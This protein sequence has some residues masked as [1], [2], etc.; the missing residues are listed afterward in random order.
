MRQAV[1]AV[2]LEKKQAQ[3]APE[4]YVSVLRVCL[5]RFHGVKMDMEYLKLTIN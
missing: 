1:F 3:F 4:K 5:R 2:P